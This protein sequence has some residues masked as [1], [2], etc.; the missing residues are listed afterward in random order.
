MSENNFDQVLDYRL[1]KEDETVPLEIP[2][3]VDWE[4]FK[5]F[6]TIKSKEGET[7]L[8]RSKYSSMRPSDGDIGF[9]G[10]VRLINN[11]FHLPDDEWIILIKN[12]FV[13]NWLRREKYTDKRKNINFKV[14]TIFPYSIQLGCSVFTD[15]KPAPDGKY[16]K[17]RFSSIVVMDG[18]VDNL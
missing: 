9:L 13:S 4:D 17:G 8:F 18:K 2:T 6:I 11:K 3:D 7:L 10:G 5:Y 1:F 14:E 16:Y 15:G 12:G